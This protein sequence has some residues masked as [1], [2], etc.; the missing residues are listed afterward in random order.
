[1]R[2]A[3]PIDSHA[4]GHESRPSLQ[5]EHYGEAV[6][7]TVGSPHLS[8]P[9]LRQKLT[10]QLLAALHDLDERGL[11]LRVLEIG[12]G[13]GG[14]TEPALAAGAEVMAVDMSRPALRHLES[15]Y[16]TNPGLRCH[17][18]ADGSLDEVEGGYTLLLCVSVLH[19]IPDYAAFLD[20][21]LE[22]LGPGASVLTLQDPLWY[23]RLSKGVHAVDRG[24]F[25]TWRLSQGNLARGLASLSRRLTH[26]MR[27]DKPGDMVEYHVLREGVDEQAIVELLEGRFRGVSLLPYWSNQL[28]IMQRV[29]RRLGL[30]NTFGVWARDLLPP[31]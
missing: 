18:S 8:D 29:G 26:R 19:H 31:E 1:M 21:A 11:P 17:F 28:P 14:Y 12:A 15:R 25:L 13:H 23:S 27:D 24:S 30:A 4:G 5:E 2:S 16:G 6:D 9:V 22:H 10:T 7:Y 3:E 20:A